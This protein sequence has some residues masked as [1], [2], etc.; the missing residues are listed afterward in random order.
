M[1]VMGGHSAPHQ[2]TMLST[3]HSATAVMSRK[4]DITATVRPLPTLLRWVVRHPDLPVPR[5]LTLGAFI[6]HDP[7]AALR[8]AAWSFAVSQVAQHVLGPLAG[9]TGHSKHLKLA[10]GL[11]VSGVQVVRTA[12][13]HGAEHMTIRTWHDTGSTELEDIRLRS[14]VD[15]KCG[16]RFVLPALLVRAAVSRFAKSDTTKLW[17][18]LA[19]LEAMLWFDH[20]HGLD[21]VPGLT[22]ASRLLQRC[23]TTRPPGDRELLTA[24]RAM[25][26]LVAASPGGDGGGPVPKV[27]VAVRSSATRA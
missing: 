11:L 27:D 23:A 16:G 12:R 3:E 2:V 9:R 20:L 18:L 8:Q 14:P 1:R 10:A 7:R 25:L 4:G 17:S 24:H 21:R 6:L 26:E 13:W 15:D 22:L 19:G 5:L